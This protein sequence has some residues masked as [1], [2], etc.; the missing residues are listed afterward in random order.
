MNELRVLVGSDRNTVQGF[1]NDMFGNTDVPTSQSK[2]PML[3]PSLH[4]ISKRQMLELIQSSK[5]IPENNVIV[6]DFLILQ[7]YTE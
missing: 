1:I 3:E 5:K 7:I 4:W 6:L 2:P